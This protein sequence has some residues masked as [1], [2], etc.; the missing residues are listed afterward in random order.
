MQYWYALNTKPR[1]ER[2][3]ESFLRGRGIEVY[4]PTIPAPRRSRSFQERAFFPNYLFAKTDLEAVGLW[5]LHYAPGMRGVVMFG[6][7]PSRVDLRVI[8]ALR[9]RLANVDVVD[10][11]GEALGPGDR[12]VVTAGPL[13]EWEAVFDRRLSAQGRVRVL[14]HLLKRWT[15]VEL[16][17]DM[18]K[19]TGGMPRRDLVA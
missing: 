3:V 9:A 13:A 11:L 12:V 15:P 4:F 8:A 6:G 7:I 1:K 14:I 2:Q 17:A 19:K 5:T 16:Q 18:L 10:V